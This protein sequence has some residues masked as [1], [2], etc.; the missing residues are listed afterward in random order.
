MFCVMI[1]LDNRTAMTLITLSNYVWVRPE[2]TIGVIWVTQPNPHTKI[3]SLIKVAA[4][5]WQDCN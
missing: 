3:A 2:E 5:L 1:I 4:R